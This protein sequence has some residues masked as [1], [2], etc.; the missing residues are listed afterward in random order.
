MWDIDSSAV[1][2]MRISISCDNPVKIDKRQVMM[3]IGFETPNLYLPV[4]KTG[5]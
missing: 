2:S 3:G 4:P 5:S 1:V